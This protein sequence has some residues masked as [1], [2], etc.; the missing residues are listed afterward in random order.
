[1]SRRSWLVMVVLAVVGAAV[2][3]GCGY[4]EILHRSVRFNA[5]TNVQTVYTSANYTVLGSVKAEGESRCI[6]LVYH[7]GTVGQ[8]LLW[9][10]A[11]ERY[12]D[13]VTAIKDITAKTHYMGILPPIYS[14]AKTTYRGTA[15]Q[16]KP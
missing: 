10:E 6:L 16:E 4:P 13:K 12:G 15:I 11:K 1:M 8:G 2:L 14:L 5:N 9:E 7:E 3:S